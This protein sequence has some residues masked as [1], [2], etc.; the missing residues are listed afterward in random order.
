M[1]RNCATQFISCQ[2]AVAALGMRVLG[3]PAGRSARY[4]RRIRRCRSR[5][6]GGRFIS[7]RSA[8]R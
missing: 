4:F 5:P 6:A 1:L 8:K 3:N 7:I 2:D